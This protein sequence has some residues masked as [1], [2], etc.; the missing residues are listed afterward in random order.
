MNGCVSG[1]LLMLV[2]KHPLWIMKNNYFL[3]INELLGNCVR[4]SI[5]WDVENYYS[6]WWQ[7]EWVRTRVQ[8]TITFNKIKQIIMFMRLKR[9]ILYR[10]VYPTRVVAQI[11]ILFW[12]C[13]FD[14]RFRKP[15]QLQCIYK[16]NYSLFTSGKYRRILR[17]A[18]LILQSFRSGLTFV[19]LDWNAMK[20]IRKTKKNNRIFDRNL[21]YLWAFIAM[22]F[23]QLLVPSSL[24]LS[25]FMQLNAYLAQKALSV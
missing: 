3:K 8:R 11:S 12:N 21:F 25:I 7:C 2:H 20:T 19:F 17:F 23:G 24:H 15:C 22:S 5:W 4:Q 6:N 16:S 13:H 18:P 9:C 10:V 1:L 14:F